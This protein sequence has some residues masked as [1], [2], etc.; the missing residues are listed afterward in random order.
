MVTQGVENFVHLEH[1]RQGF[2]QQRGFDG[3][4]RQVE[5]IFGIAEHIVPP[6]RF[7]PRLGFRHVEI[8]AATFG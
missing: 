8:G 2:N 6:G 3:P 5:A 4:A 7:L 1:G